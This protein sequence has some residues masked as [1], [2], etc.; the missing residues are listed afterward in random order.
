MKVKPLVDDTYLLEKFEGKGGWTF[1]RIPEISQDK[2]A[3]FGWR[4]VRGTIDGFEIRHY[5]LMPM[6]DGRLFL[7]VR[8]EIRKKIKK[9]AGLR[10]H[11]VLY[12]E[13][14][15]FAIPDEFEICL[16]DAPKAKRFFDGLSESEQKYYVQWIYSA[17]REDTRVSRI[18]KT[19]DRLER[20]LKMYIQQKPEL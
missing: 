3:P 15:R 5:H 17:K 9:E 7:P 12:S 2:N 4:K 1:A 14:E 19:I 6:G 18:A 10:V 13:N 16:A 20:N 8:A 11:I